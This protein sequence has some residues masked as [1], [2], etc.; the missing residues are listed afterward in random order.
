MALK[1][2]MKRPAPKWWRNLEDGLLMIM[3]PATVAVI[4]GWGFK[5]DAFVTKL[6]LFI[7]TGVVALIKFIGKLLN[8][9]EVYAQ[10][11][12]KTETLTVTQTSVDTTLP[13]S[14]APADAEQ[15]HNK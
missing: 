6:V 7:N 5:D 8:T 11:D 1:D 4:M 9:D 3:I 13:P 12:T 14:I 10:A 15:Q 2:N